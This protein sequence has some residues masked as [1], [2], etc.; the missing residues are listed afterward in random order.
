MEE[1]QLLHILMLLII[2]LNSHFSL[3]SEPDAEWASTIASNNQSML[4]ASFKQMMDLPGFDQSTREEAQNPRP[5]LQ[6]FVSSSMPI[7]LLKQY[8]FDAKHYGGVLVFRGLPDGSMQKLIKLV[9][10]ISSED[11]AA[12]QIDDEAFRDFRVNAVPTIVLSKPTSLFSDEGHLEKFDKI[13]GTITIK[14]A[15]ELFAASGDMAMSAKRLL[16]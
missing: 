11:S 1:T 10:S 16:Q 2:A 15:L 12:M 9:T 4:I 3:A 13:A 7:S 14:A 5:A 6:I 8:A